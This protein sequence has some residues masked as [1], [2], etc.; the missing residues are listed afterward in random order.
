M[1]PVPVR[2]VEIQEGFW[3]K[4]RVTNV[5]SS[6]PSMHDELVNHGRM[7]DFLRLEGKSTE[8]QK[9]PVYSDSDIY[10][11]AEAVGFALQSGDRP[12]LRATTEAMIREVV[13]AQEP[14]GYLNTYYQ[15]DR[16]GLR[17]QYDVRQR[18]TNS[19]AWDIYCRERLPLSRERRPHAARRG[20]SLCGWLSAAELRAGS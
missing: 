14:S 10:K 12:D 15:G 8:P 19:I 17:M 5:D 18:G 7:D 16:K 9:G 3:S 20:H 1:K 4:R 13:A 2:A 6:I 11:W